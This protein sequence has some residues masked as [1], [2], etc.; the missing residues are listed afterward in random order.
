M[1]A[2]LKPGPP[3]KRFKDLYRACEN[4]PLQAAFTVPGYKFVFLCPLY[5]TFPISPIGPLGRNCLKVESNEFDDGNLERL[6]NVQK[7]ALLHELVH[8]YLGRETLGGETVPREEYDPN[9]CV[10]FV[11]KFSLRNPMNYQFFVASKFPFLNGDQRQF[12]AK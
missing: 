8:F 4:D 3:S 10:N 2:C 5:F 11:E 7:Y 6:V 1:F 12:L 9:E